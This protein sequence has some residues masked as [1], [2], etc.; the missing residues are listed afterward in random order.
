[1][2]QDM[3]LSKNYLFSLLDEHELSLMSAI[4]SRRSY[5]KGELLFY[6]GETPKM[7]LM[8]EEGC[9]QVYKHDIHGNEIHIAFFQPYEMIAEMAHFEEIPYPATARCESDVVVLEIDFEALKELMAHSAEL[10]LHIIRSL[11]RKIK[12]LEAKMRS[13]MVDDASTR[14]ARFL[15]EHE[16]DIGKITQ[17][18]IAELLSLTPETVSRLLRQF[19]EKGWVQILQK[20]L[21]ICDVEALQKYIYS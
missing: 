3:R 11:G 1:M 19:K 10:S 20:K 17:R 8:V 13:I 2:D 15:V 5:T 18:K 21:H 12:Q 4:T 9:V 16:K 14:L 6:A 7:L